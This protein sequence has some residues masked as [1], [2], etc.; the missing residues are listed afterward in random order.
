MSKRLFAE[1]L[2]VELDRARDNTVFVGDSPNDE[3]M[4]R[5]FPERG[6]GGESAP[7]PARLAEPAALGDAGRRGARASRN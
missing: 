6:R 1:V 4:F 5:L 3:P 7:L 2:G